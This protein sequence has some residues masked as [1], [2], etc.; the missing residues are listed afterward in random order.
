MQTKT[1]TTTSSID[2]PMSC[3]SRPFGQPKPCGPR[4]VDVQA[5]F[6]VVPLCIRGPAFA[7]E[8]WQDQLR[9]RMAWALSQIF[10]VSANGFGMDD[11]TELWLNYYDAWS[12][13]TRAHEQSS[14]VNFD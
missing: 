13:I 6:D 3:P 10:V 7:P 14:A 8:H 12:P 11:R 9:Q 5:C 2:L 1:S 4:T